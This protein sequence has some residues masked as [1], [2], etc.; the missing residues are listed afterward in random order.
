MARLRTG[1]ATAKCPCGARLYRQ[2]VGRTAALHAITDTTPITR[3]R[4]QQAR[5]RNRLT[6]CLI[7]GPH[8]DPELRWRCTHRDCGHTVVIDHQ[9][10]P[11]EPTTLF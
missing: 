10:P 11:T 4:E 9:C 5:T 1:A 6:W 8:R 2:L 3:E 7:T